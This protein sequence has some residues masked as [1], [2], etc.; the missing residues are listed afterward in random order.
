MMCP[1]AELLRREG[2]D[3]AKRRE[4]PG[5]H[6][7]YRVPRNDPVKNAQHIVSIIV[8]IDRIAARKPDMRDTRT[9]KGDIRPGSV[10]EGTITIPGDRRKK[11][12]RSPVR[13]DI[14][15]G[16]VVTVPGRV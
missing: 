11:A 2:G 7:N 10:P 6:W 1:S 4:N 5:P 13:L 12:A 8:S 15:T 14:V 3:V 9:R 16:E